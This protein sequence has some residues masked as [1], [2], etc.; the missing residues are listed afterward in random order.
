MANA[1]QLKVIRQG[2]AAWN[3]WRRAN[4]SLHVDLS[5]ADL[6]KADLVGADLV[7]ADLVGADLVGADLSRAYL[8][9]A[10]LS[11]AKLFEANLA[12]CSLWQT[13]FVGTT[14]TGVRGLESI[15]HVGPS[16]LDHRTFENSPGLPDVFLR[17]VGLPDWLIDSFRGYAGRGPIDFYSCFISYSHTDKSFARRLHDQL[18]AR[19]VRCWLDEKQILPGDDIYAAVERGL[20]LW[21]KVLLCLYRTRFLGHDF[22]IRGRA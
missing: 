18:Q 5:K 8:G 16:T 1:E 21:D 3:D 14:L 2:T 22:A 19:G 9:R 7:G 4:P 13:R 20:R 17:G 10:D 11:D 15:N 6:S 12:D